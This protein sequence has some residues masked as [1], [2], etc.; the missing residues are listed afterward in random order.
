M[1]AT[2][3]RR[4]SSPSRPRRPAPAE[5]SLHLDG[6]HEPVLLA[7][8]LHALAPGPGEIAVDATLGGG[9]VAASLLQRILP[10]GRVLALDRDPVA[11]ALAQSRF[12][13]AGGA[14]TARVGRFSELVAIA[15]EEAVE[16]DL[17]VMDLGISS[18][19][20]DDP[21]RG[22]SFQ[23]EGPLDM[24]LDPTSG[25]MTAA[26]IVATYDLDQLAALIADFGQ[27]RHS[28]A[29]ARAIVDQRRG[30]AI[31]STTQLARICAGAIPRRLWP[32]R[33]HPATRTFLALRIAVN[34]ELDELSSGIAAAIHILRPGG[35]LGII[36]FHSLEDTIA[37]RS[38]H[39]LALVCVC[40]P[41]QPICTCAHRATLSL[42]QRRAIRPSPAEVERNPR[43][44]SALL[45]TAI[46][47]P[48]PIP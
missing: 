26:D 2:M 30:E 8:L 21:A 9:G 43:A 44:R 48:T 3:S 41:Q 35:R 42:P 40:P 10:G 38:L 17:V 46:K 45:R 1:L 37:K 5:S 36:S 11:V 31:T 32:P 25:G 13:A 47:L 12:A 20:L 39:N 14:F 15:A 18:M 29:I 4:R 7:E 23:R 24:R 28:R 6:V 27:E 22:F 16:A 34:Q 19:Q 33:I